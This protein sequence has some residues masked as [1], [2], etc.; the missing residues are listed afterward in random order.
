MFSL[1]RKDLIDEN[2]LLTPAIAM[3]DT[4]NI[5]QLSTKSFGDININIQWTLENQTNNFSIRY[6][7][8]LTAK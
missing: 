8:S 3:N 2:P 6:S 4:K 7:F 5:N 1:N